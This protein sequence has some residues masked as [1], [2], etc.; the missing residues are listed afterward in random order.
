MEVSFKIK[1]PTKSNYNFIICEKVNYILTDVSFK[2]KSPPRNNKFIIC[3]KVT[4]YGCKF[5]VKIKF[6]LGS[7]YHFIIVKR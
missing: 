2:I 3:E 4:I 7:N 1:F 5:S 6:T